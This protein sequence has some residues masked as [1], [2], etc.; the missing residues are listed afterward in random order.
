MK[1]IVTE[2]DQ[3]RKVLGAHLAAGR[4]EEATRVYSD[5]FENR[6]DHQLGELLDQA[7]A[8]QRIGVESALETRG[9]S[10]RDS[11]DHLCRSISVAG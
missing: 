2:I 4:T 11:V 9:G 10:L 7:M 6:L 8:R 5:E 1:R 3:S